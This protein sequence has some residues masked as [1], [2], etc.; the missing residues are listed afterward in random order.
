[1]GAPFSHL[2]RVIV[3]A[4]VRCK[5]AGVCHT[6]SAWHKKVG[7][8]QTGA[9]LQCQRPEMHWNMLCVFLKAS[10]RE[11]GPALFLLTHISQTSQGSSLCPS[12]V[13]PTKLC[14]A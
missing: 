1:M 13:P 3:A 6:V 7:Q 11:S 12:L 8:R 9:D 4:I 10:T 5:Q 14:L 2:G